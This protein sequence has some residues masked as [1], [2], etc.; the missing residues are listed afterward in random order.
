MEGAAAPWPEVQTRFA[1]D[2]VKID[3]Q[4]DIKLL[5]PL[6][7]QKTIGVQQIDASVTSTCDGA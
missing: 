1:K 6:T 2:A 5:P 7:S 3:G 4:S